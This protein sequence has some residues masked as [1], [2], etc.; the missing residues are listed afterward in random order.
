MV[1]LA[2]HGEPLKKSG[3]DSA[4]QRFIR[5]AIEKEVI[6]V[7]QRF[8]VHD[9]KLRGGIDTPDTFAEKQQALGLTEQMMKTYDKSVPEVAPSA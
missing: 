8:G 4:W 2:E 6:T 7:D 1:I 5:L 9:L 3:L